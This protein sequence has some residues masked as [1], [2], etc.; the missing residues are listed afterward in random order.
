MRLLPQCSLNVP[1][2]DKV[3]V[4]GNEAVR[5]AIEEES[6]RVARMVVR[7]S[8][9]EPLVRIFAEADSMRAAHGAAERVRAQILASED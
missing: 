9:T 3:R 1:V 4:L 7:A 2:R 6:A 5:A 8:G